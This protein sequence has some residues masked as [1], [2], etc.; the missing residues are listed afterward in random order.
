MVAREAQMVISRYELVYTELCEFICSR[1]AHNV[2]SGG[3][4]TAMSLI[5]NYVSIPMLPM[6]S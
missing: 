3:H 5:P 6:T 1:G 4:D 2:T